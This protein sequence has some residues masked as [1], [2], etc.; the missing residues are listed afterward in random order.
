M[1][2]SPPSASIWPARIAT[3]SV[4]I[5]TSPPFALIAASGSFIRR[6]RVTP[7]PPSWIKFSALMFTSPPSMRPAFTTSPPLANR[8]I[9]PFWTDTLEAACTP[10]VLTRLSTMLLAVS[11]VMM[12]PLFWTSASSILPLTATSTRPSP[13]MSR[14]TVSPEAITTFPILALMI[15]L[16]TIKGET[17]A[18][19][20]ASL[21]VI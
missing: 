6:A 4:S 2:M 20:P 19:K 16:F 18:A 8:V 9:F 12:T 15:P 13:Y 10:S 7:A 5:L 1:L 21:T 14:V 3:F 11:V 17:N